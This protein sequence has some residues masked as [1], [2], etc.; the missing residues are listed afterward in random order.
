M[1]IGAV[2]GLFF[3][4]TTVFAA[5]EVI[6]GGDDADAGQVEPRRIDLVDRVF[7]STN[8]GFGL[9]EDGLAANDTTLIIDGSRSVRVVEGTP[10]EIMC[11]ELGE[12]GVCAVVADLLGEGVVWFALVPMGS[13]DTVE[14]PAIDVLEDGRARLVNG[15]ELPYA[16]ILNRRC[17]DANGDEVEFDS[18]RDFRKALGDDFTSNYS[19]ESRRLEAVVCGERVPY[20]PAAPTTVPSSSPTDRSS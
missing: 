16:P 5:R 9:D 3:L 13:G 8:P 6:E 20:A 1:A 7:S 4:L 15:W 18:Y 11:P 10:G 12:L 17:R 14:F 19:I 2:V